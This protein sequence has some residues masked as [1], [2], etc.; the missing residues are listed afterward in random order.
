MGAKSQAKAIIRPAKTTDF[1]PI[2]RNEKLCYPTPWSENLLKQTL[3]QSCIGQSENQSSIGQSENSWELDSQE[4]DQKL[5][6]QKKPEKRRTGQ[7]EFYL[8]EVNHQIAGH[9]VMQRIL[10]EIHLHNICIAP[11]Y[12][13]LGYGKQWLEFLIQEATNHQCKSILLEVRQSNQIAT[14]FYLKAGFSQIGYRKNYYTTFDGSSEDAL[15][16]KRVV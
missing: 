7:S 10:D 11:Q 15:V 14:Q 8:M 6:S 16:M 9:L 12:Q 3:N 5:D 1:E 4:L 2:L 13:G